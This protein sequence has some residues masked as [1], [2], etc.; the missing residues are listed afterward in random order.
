MLNLTCIFFS[1]LDPTRVSYVW[2]KDR[3]VVTGQITNELIINPIQR[4]DNNTAYTCESVL[5]SPYL[6]G[7]IGDTSEIYQL[8]ILG[9]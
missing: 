4:T 6:S 9:K 7:T 5:T 3:Q 1:S 8:I 2:R